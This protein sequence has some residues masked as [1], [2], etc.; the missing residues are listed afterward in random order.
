MSASS[1]K[2][3]VGHMDDKFTENG[4]AEKKKKVKSD[5]AKDKPRPANCYLEP[6]NMLDQPREVRQQAWRDWRDARRESRRFA[7]ARLREA[8]AL[9]DPNLIELW[10]SRMHELGPDEPDSLMPNFSH[11]QSISS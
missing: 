2:R 8:L 10:K 7:F 9:G 3:E 1:G 6:Q 11:V 4:E 5:S